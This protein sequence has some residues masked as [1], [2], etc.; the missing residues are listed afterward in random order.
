M[1]RFAPSPT[2]DMDI[3]TLRVALL[4]YLVATQRSEPF[5]VRIED[6]DKERNIEGK[7]TEFMQILEKFAIRHDQVYH[8][9]EHRN[10]HL[11]LAVRLLEEEKAF[12]CTCPVN[13]PETDPCRGACME[14]DASVYTRLK[15]SGEPF[16][17]RIRKPQGNIIFHDLIQGDVVTAPDAIESFVILKADA[18]PTQDFATACDDMLSNISLIIRQEEQL[19]HT[20]KQIHIK[21][22][23]GYQEETQYAHL[24]ALLNEEG[25]TL[26]GKDETFWLKWFFEQG[27]IPDA[28]INYLILLGSSNAPGEIFYFPEAHEWFSLGDLSTSPVRFELDRLR[29]INREHLRMMDDKRLS[30]LF[31]FAD[32]DI[33]KLAKVYLEEASTINELAARI[34]P[35]L[36]P[37]RFEGEWEASMRQIQHALIDAPMFETF[38]ELKTY[39]AE[40]TGLKGEA[41]LTPLRLLLT[42]DKEGPELD[43]IYPCIRSYLLEVIS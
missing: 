20:P 23:L 24:P 11:T 40:E 17:V 33:G 39:V 5:L 29:A 4:N 35:I 1:L 9:S 16:V 31:G 10:I 13:D 42:G 3:G 36:A 37:K 2:G 7:D 12:V 21:Q 32:A 34:R 30:T 28:L 41:L 15:E 22:E 43:R 19:L 25:E 26:S 14:A 8:Q 18:T 27:F 38:D 6:I